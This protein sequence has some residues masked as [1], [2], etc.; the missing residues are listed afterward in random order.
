VRVRRGRE[1][2]A[3]GA[4]VSSLK[5]ETEDVREVRAGFECGISVNGFE[6]FI[7]GDIIEFLVRE[8]VS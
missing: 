1:V 6:D 4:S 2:L 7:P 5:R 3:D 8:R